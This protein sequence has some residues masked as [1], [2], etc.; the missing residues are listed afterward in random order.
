MLG[1]R[2]RWPGGATRSNSDRCVEPCELLVAIC[3]GGMNARS[4]VATG[5][6]SGGGGGGNGGWAALNRGAAAGPR[7]GGGGVG[8]YKWSRLR[9]AFGI[10]TAGPRSGGGGVAYV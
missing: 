5:V 9:D 2:R 4:S 8:A 1:I 3:C 6:R 7:S 10:R